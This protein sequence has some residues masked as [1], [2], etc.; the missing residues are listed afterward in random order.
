M[1][2]NYDTINAAAGK[3]SGKQIIIF[4]LAAFLPA[5]VLQV[6]ASQAAL[7]G[8]TVTFSLLISAPWLPVRPITAT[9]SNSRTGV[10]IS[11]PSWA[12]VRFPAPSSPGP[13]TI[14][15]CVIPIC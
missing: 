2:K 15:T 9:T 4:L 12:S 13:R 7:K 1:G 11:R 8:D 14:P 6:I 5:W 3:R 10:V